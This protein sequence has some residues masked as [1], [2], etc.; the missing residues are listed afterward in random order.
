INA[1]SETLLIGGAVVL[2]GGYFL[3]T[4]IIPKLNPFP[5]ATDPVSTANN[6][7][8]QVAA[9]QQAKATGQ[10]ETYTADQYIGWA[11]DI[12]RLG[13]S[14][15]KLDATSMNAIVEDVTNCNNMVDLQS[16][17]NAFGTKQAGG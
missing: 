12:Y 8:A 14:M 11:N 4:K 2:V 3:V 7:A 5:T 1:N 10:K 6:A 9:R 13:T 17:I 16:L 15:D